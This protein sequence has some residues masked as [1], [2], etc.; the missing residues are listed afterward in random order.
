[1]EVPGSYA[2]GTYQTPAVARVDAV[3]GQILQLNR[4]K[5]MGGSAALPVLMQKS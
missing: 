1:M 4:P 2:S 3:T 5:R